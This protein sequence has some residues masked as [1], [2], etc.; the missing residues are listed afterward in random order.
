MCRITEGRYQCCEQECFAMGSVCR[1]CCIN[2][3]RRNPLHWIEEWNSSFF[4]HQSLQGLELR[5]QLG[6]ELGSTCPCS[7]PAS[8]DFA[9]LH[10]NGIHN[11]SVDFCACSLATERR[12]QLLRAS[13]W[14]AMPTDPQTAMTFPLLHLFHTLNCQGKMPAFDMWKGLEIMTENRTGR[15]PPDRYKVLLRTIRQWRHLKQCKRAGHGHDPTGVQGTSLGELALECLACPHPGWNMPE[16]SEIEEV[17]R[18]TCP[19]SWLYTLFIALDVN[20]CVRN[21]VVSSDEQDPPLSDGWGYFVE[22]GPYLEHLH[23]FV[24]QEEISTCSGFAATFLANIKNVRGLRTTGVVGCTCARHGVW[25]KRGFG[26]LQHGERHCNVDG[27][28]VQALNDV[29][30]EVVISYDIVCQWGIHFWERMAEF[31]DDAHLKLTQD[32]IIMCMPKFHLWAHKPQCHARFSFNYVHGSGQTHRETIEENW[33][34]SNKASA[35]TKMMGPGARQDTLDDIFGFHNYRIME[36]FA[37]KEARVH[38]DD[39]ERFDEGIISY[40][41]KAT[42]AQ[43]LALVTAWEKDHSRPCPYEATLQGNETLQERSM[44]RRKGQVEFVNHQ[45][46]ALFSCLAYKSRRLSEHILEMEVKALAMGTVYQQLNIQ[47]QRSSLLRKIN[48]FRG[49]QQVFM[50]NLRLVLSPSKLRHL[51]ASSAFNV[52]SIKLFMPSELDDDNQRARVCTPGVAEM[53]S[54]MHEAESHDSLQRLRSSLRNRAASHLFTVKNVTGQNSTTQNQGILRTIQMNIH[55]NKLRYRYSRNVLF[56]LRGHGPWEDELRLLRDEDIRGLNERLQT[57][58]ELHEQQRLRDLGVMDATG[59]S[60]TNWNPAQ[61]GDSRRVLS[62]IWYD[63]GTKDNTPKFTALCIEWCKARARML[64]WEEEIQLL[65]EEM[66]RVIS[67]ADWKAR[68]WS[69]RAELRPDASPELQE[70]LKA[71]ALEHTISEGCKKARVAE[72]WAPLRRLAQ[73]YQRNLPVE[74]ILEYQLQE[75]VVE[76]EV[77]DDE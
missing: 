77:V 68:W 49:L 35:Q 28:V 60:S 3:H 7:S 22:K 9:V 20:Y 39:F 62:W 59:E 67:F 25:Q 19:Q 17:K 24:S 50:P 47:K 53:E 36:S 6:H 43:W 54:R 45:V 12:Q 55:A 41:G 74:I 18:L 14:P 72:K 1:A 46:L 37:I 48:R 33:A 42:T 2:L 29:E 69:E 34:D 11:V 64:R 30:V 40:C 75:E 52:E 10:S 32:A 26:N 65:D 8:K 44:R 66:R 58:D 23:K 71:F 70:G 5:M 76:E 27:V 61:R 16:V 73:E 13:W 4:Q 63:S 15:R 21:A 38:R 31:P 56:R 57:E 51:D